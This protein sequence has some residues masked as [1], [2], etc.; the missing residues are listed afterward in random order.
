M[1]KLT[2]LPQT[3]E[4]I[5]DGV[6]QGL[7]VGPTLFYIHINCIRGNACRSSMFLYAD[8]IEG[9]RSGLNLK[10]VLQD[11]TED[12]QNI[13]FGLCFSLLKQVDLECEEI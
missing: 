3:K 2:V 10:V 11:L 1:N 8:D 7:L 5:D 13:A 9:H 12:M 4:S 6:P